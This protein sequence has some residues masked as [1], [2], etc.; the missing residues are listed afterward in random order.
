MYL[1]DVISII[2]EMKMTFNAL[3]VHRYLYIDVV[4]TLAGLDSRGIYII[5]SMIYQ[6]PN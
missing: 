6:P 1:Y 3:C 5:N 2:G 4:C